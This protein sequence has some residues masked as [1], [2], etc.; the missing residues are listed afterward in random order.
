MTFKGNRTWVQ[1]IDNFISSL[2][3]DLFGAKIVIVGMNDVSMK[4]A[5]SLSERGGQV[6]IYEGKNSI[7]NN[8]I[9]VLNEVKMSNLPF[10]IKKFKDKN[11][12]KD[13]ID[14]L[15]G[16]NR[17]QKIDME[18]IEKMNRNGI[19]I[20]AVFESIDLDAINLASKYNI[21]IFRIDMKAAMAGEMTTVLRT[22]NM[23]KDTGKNY[24]GDIPII[25]STYM[26]AKGDIV[27]D[28][29]LNPTEVIGVADGIG[30]ILYDTEDYSDIVKKT[31]IE[32]V[33]RQ[34]DSKE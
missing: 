15:V 18:M 20:D 12:F 30:N 11:E 13:G 7:E 6:Y 5:I 4:L 21:Q 9:K 24:I 1:A 26:G 10:E 28:S 34:I 17:K 16:F 32:I 29:I 2:W 14:I 22:H 8:I 31:E 3:F 33:K 23:I 19:I 27:V 25:S